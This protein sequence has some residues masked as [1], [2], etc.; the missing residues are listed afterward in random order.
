MEAELGAVKEMNLF[1]GLD[2]YLE[3]KQAEVV[4]QAEC[5][6]RMVERL[7]SHS[8]IHNFHHHEPWYASSYRPKLQ[9]PD[10]LTLHRSLS[11]YYLLSTKSCEDIQPRTSFQHPR[12]S[13]HLQIRYT[14]PISFKHITNLG[15]PLTSPKAPLNNVQHLVPRHRNPT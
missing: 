11:L 9:R 6:D 4:P 8:M 15:L 3:C 10:C 13:S 14:V 5:Q 12:T 1:Y 7:L 2:P